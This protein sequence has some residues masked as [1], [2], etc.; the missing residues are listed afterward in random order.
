LS[1]ELP[2][3]V[4]LEFLP[5]IEEG[6]RDERNFVKK[7]VN[8]A[9]RH[10][11]KRNRALNHAALDTAEKIRACGGKAARWIASDAMRELRSEAV[12]ARLET[13]KG[14]AE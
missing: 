1:A 3:S 9:L 11:G 6:S 13:R 4:F 7:A 2:Y 14:K 8:W 12:Q 5:L 10:I